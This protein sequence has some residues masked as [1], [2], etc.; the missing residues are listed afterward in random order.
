[1][2]YLYY[3]KREFRFLTLEI[4]LEII[5]LNKQSLTF[6]SKFLPHKPLKL[7]Q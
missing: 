4:S 5:L 1:M 2:K 6:V 7:F 3:R